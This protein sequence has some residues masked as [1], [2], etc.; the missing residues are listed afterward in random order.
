MMLAFLS[1]LF[2]LFVL[3]QVF[4]LGENDGYLVNAPAASWWAMIYTEID[5]SRPT[6]VKTRHPGFEPKTYAFNGGA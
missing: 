6:P 5:L 2:T 4:T 3:L 1:G